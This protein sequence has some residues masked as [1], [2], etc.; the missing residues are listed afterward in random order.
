MQAV[1]RK[2][3]IHKRKSPELNGVTE[4][5]LRII[6]NA[7]LAA[8]IQAPILFS[9]V[10]LPLSETSWS[11]AIHWACEALNRTATTS[12]LGSKSL[13]EMWHVKPAPASP[14]PFLRP[15]Y[16]RWNCPTKSFP[17]C[18]SNSYLG[19]G[20]NHP[21]Y[22]LGMLMRANKVME[23]RYVTWEAPP[24]ME[25]PPVHLQQLASPE[26]AGVPEFGRTSKQAGASGLG[27]TAEPGRLDDFDSGPATRLPT[28]GR[29]IP[30]HSR[31]AFSAGSVGNGGQGER[32]S[33]DG[34]SMPAPD[35]TTTSSRDCLSSVSSESSVDGE[36]PGEVSSSDE[37]GL[38]T[39][40]ARTAAPQLESHLVGPGD[41]EQLGQTRFFFF[42][43]RRMG[44]NKALAHHTS[45]YF[46][47][48]RVSI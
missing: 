41:G 40:M 6:Q 20:I 3:G 33:V 1:L 39:T 10:E 44:K 23:T 36:N 5:A 31:V 8:R 37:N 46:H 32:G 15:G 11:E 47:T 25:V 35:A 12:N 16:C 42:I 21:R 48:R 18:E 9:H 13:Y 29:E 2:T 30:H 27:E 4:R 45:T 26:L 24:V 17:W 34:V 22:S 19:P 28:L 38:V 7:A 14:H 43:L